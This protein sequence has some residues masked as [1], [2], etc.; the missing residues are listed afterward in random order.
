MADKRETDQR[1][2]QSTASEREMNE[3][4]KVFFKTCEELAKR[5]GKPEISRDTDGYRHF[6]VKT[7]PLSISVGES[8]NVTFVVEAGFGMIPTE[9]G[10]P[11]PITS[12]ISYMEKDP[13][14]TCLSAYQRNGQAH[15]HIYKRSDSEYFAPRTS[16]V[17]RTAE[18]KNASWTIKATFEDFEKILPKVS[19][20]LIQLG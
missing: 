18:L 15:C 20:G 13:E 14:M 2:D 11:K 8:E 3:R 1:E 17:G 7:P 6:S 5:Y 10:K 12:D 9:W 16:D 4:S 19:E